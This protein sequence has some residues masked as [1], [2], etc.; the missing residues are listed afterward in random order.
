LLR[1]RAQLR[2]RVAVAG[3]F[4]P[5]AHAPGSPVTDVVVRRLDR[6]L[7][8]C[9]EPRAVIGEERQHGLV[10]AFAAAEEAFGFLRRQIE[11]IEEWPV[12]LGR[13][14]VAH[15]EDTLA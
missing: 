2:R 8:Q 1:D 15:E 11:A 3:D 10:L 13:R 4:T 7:V 14:A 9:E 5:I 6:R 12:A